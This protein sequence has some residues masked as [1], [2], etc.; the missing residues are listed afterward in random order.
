MH[1]SYTDKADVWSLGCVLYQMATG[2]PAFAGSNPL[3]VAQKIV[4]GSY[5]AI[6]SSYSPL[7]HEMVRRLLTVDPNAR[8]DILAVS[9]LIS[10]L[11]MAELDRVNIASERA[12]A[13]ALHEAEA[14]KRERDEW[15]REKQTYRK[16]M[17]TATINNQQK[18]NLQQQQ[19]QQQQ[20]AAA[21]SSS[22]SAAAGH[23][24][25]LGGRAGRSASSASSLPAAGDQHLPEFSPS[26]PVA[27][28]SASASGSAG[29]SQA[30]GPSG[31]GGSE[32]PSSSSASAA[33]SSQ[34]ASSSS[35]SSSS[36]SLRPPPSSSPLFRVSSS[37]VRPTSHDPLSLLL[38]QLHKIV[39]VS[40]LP[41]KSV[42]DL[43][44]TLITR[45]KHGLFSRGFHAPTFKQELQQIVAGSQDAVDA[46]FELPHIDAATLLTS[47]P[48][49]GVGAGLLPSGLTAASANSQQQ[50]HPITHEELQLLIEQVLDEA[51]YYSLP[52]AQQTHNN[53]EGQ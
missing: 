28:A 4:A 25:P 29:G 50:Q 20:Q 8:P 39:W 2:R 23:S 43:K 35:N 31:S 37:A 7:F 18:W 17:A 5:D 14:R 41:P 21:A 26:P 36:P 44:R 27:A 32:D 42:R 12:A 34:L 49:G 53:A 11:L 30:G 52:L 48:A 16:W 6:P 46:R 40:Q 9:S 10:P 51:G 19:Q 1:E 22:S 13:Q 24:P 47:S 33:A 3:T 45:Y 15:N 38:G